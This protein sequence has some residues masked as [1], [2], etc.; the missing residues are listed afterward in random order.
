VTRFSRRTSWFKVLVFGGICA[1]PGVALAEPV[2][3][4]SAAAGGG[5]QAL[6]VF[7]VKGDVVAAVCATAPCSA[8]AVSLGV[9]AALRGKPTR[10]DVVSLGSGRRAIV[11]TIADGT[12]TFQAVVAAPLT[13]SAPKLIFAGLVGLIKGQ[14]GT[15]S[16]PMVQIS[17]AMADGTRRVLVG[18]QNEGA[19]L[20]GRPTILAPQLLSPQDL[21]LHNAKVQRLS[22][23]E[24]D[25]A[26][27]VKATRLP[28]DEPSHAA[29][30][31]LSALAASTAI[32]APQAVTDG[33]PETTWSENV[34]GDGKGEFVI[35]HAPP[36]L[37][38]SGLELTIRPKLKSL[39]DG[40]APE[41]LFIVGPRD[42]V[43]V[44]LPEDA[45]QSPGARY[46]VTLEPPLQSSCIGLVL[47]TAFTQ[48]KTA[49]VTIAEMSVLSELSQSQLPEL[50]ATLAGGGQRAEAAKSLLV[51]GGPAAFAAVAAAF[52]QLDEG[53]KRVALDVL[54]QAPCEQS[55]PV[56]VA[57][58]TGKIDAQARHAQTRLAR[59]GAAGGEA[60]AQA[61]AKSD[62]TDKRLMPL[63]VAQL[64]LTDPARAVSA[65]LPLM[66]EKTVLRRR[67]LRSAL[68]Q[69]AR[70][71]AAKNAVRAAL[72]DPKTSP[73]A[74]IDLLRALGDQAPRF[75]PEAD[76]ALKRLSLNEP[77]FRSRFLLLGPTAVLSAES[78]EAAA[79][80]RTSLN[81]DPDPH[82]RAGALALVE[83]P[84]RFQKE[85]LHA[86]ADRDVRVR[87]AAVQALSSPN[88]AFASRALGER[89]K[90]DQWPLVRAAAADALAK[91]PAGAALDAPL[92]AALTD[93][94]PLVRARSIRALGDRQVRGASSRIR[95]RLADGDEWPEVRAEA[96]RTL[97]ILCDA[98]SVDELGAFA[99]KLSD[100]MASPD[101]QLIATAS[102]ISLGRLAPPNLQQLLAP[103]SDKK[104]PAQAR[105]A[106]A[107][108]L[109]ARDG[110]R[111]PAPR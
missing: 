79:E 55:A 61:L 39:P 21:E 11:V 19:S 88:A 98:E 29:R 94:S 104:A 12:Q 13:G 80:F 1:A 37:P 20:C 22:V 27:S 8:G 78:P 99:K 69:A 52:D 38:I 3:P 83:Q 101:A 5:Q 15:R 35:M 73:V 85:L 56:F 108:A 74:L 86:L 49:Q 4:A 87:E 48:A 45:W 17:E 84:Q 110:C 90:D 76:Q 16:G 77:S 58:L 51:A 10:A 68:A 23:K 111:A 59:C 24:R 2:L 50:V 72:V 25:A 57:A 31:V 67:L 93:D 32:G 18:E 28:D 7:A 9:P 92:T 42:V 95:D 46:H 40:A 81:G 91:H 66:D 44:S 43:Q 36:E 106:A 14:E 30:S 47:D 64:T 89:L 82:V 107:L 100:P 97:G 63:L 70:S 6:S 71:E 26:R 60:L 75:L 41:T 53:G 109:S 102:V 33:D 103:L 54:D 62:K 96:A 105:R 65:F 34:G